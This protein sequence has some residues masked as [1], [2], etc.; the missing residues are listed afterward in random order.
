MSSPFAPVQE[1]A[2][3][4][5]R[6][7]I[8]SSSAGIHVSPLQLGAMS[9]GDAWSGMIGSMSHGSSFSLLDAFTTCGGNFIDTANV[10]QNEQSETWLAEWMAARDNRDRLV[11]ATKYTMACRDYTI[12]KGVPPN[13][14]GHHKK[15]MVLSLRD[16]L[17]KLQTTYIDIF[18]VHMW[19]H[20][21]SIKEIMDSLHILVST[22]RC[23]IW[24]SVI[25]Q[26]GSTRRQISTRT[27]MERH[28]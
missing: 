28:V 18:H 12:G 4:L 23:C 19:D 25:R 21:S 10:Y 1:P 16:S 3:P 22:G 17:A 15:P 27:V 13:Y 24:T 8:L 26:L 2:S 5:A 7:R 11:L 20:N 9:V 6:Y 14:M